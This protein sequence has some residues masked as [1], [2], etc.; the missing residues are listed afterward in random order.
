METEP[1]KAFYM[2]GYSVR[3][4]K[5]SRE[6]RTLTSEPNK[7]VGSQTQKVNLAFH[8]ILVSALSRALENSIKH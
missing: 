8:S 1:D 4:L 5:K 2:I 6:E 3:D 7:V